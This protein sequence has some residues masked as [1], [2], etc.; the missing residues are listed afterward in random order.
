MRKPQGHFMVT[1]FAP[2]GDYGGV[3]AALRSIISPTGF[4]SLGVWRGPRDERRKALG[5]QLRTKLS[6]LDNIDGL[7]DTEKVNNA[8]Q[9][10]ACS[11]PSSASAPASPTTGRSSCGPRTRA[12]P[13]RPRMLE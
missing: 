2:D 10:Q 6:N 9:L 13:C 1:Y 7:R 4:K 8:A 5:E 3:P 11:S 12:R